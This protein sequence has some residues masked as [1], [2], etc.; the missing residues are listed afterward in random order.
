MNHTLV[1][2]TQDHIEPARDLFLESYSRESKH[3]PLLPS[4]I[5]DEPEWLL[6]E[7]EELIGN[8]GVAIIHKNQLI[9]YM[10]T[11]LQF[12]FKGQDAVVVSEYCHAAI[13]MNKSELYKRMYLHLAQEWANSH[14]HVHA[15]GHFANDTILQ[16]T[17]YQLGF[18]AILAEQLRD[19]SLIDDAPDATIIEEQDVERLVS[20]HIEH[21]AYYKASPIFILKSTNKDEVASE[22]ESHVQ[23][24]DVFLVYYEANEPCAYMIVGTSAIDEEG[25]LLQDTNTAQIK[26]A[27]ARP[28]IR[29]KGVGKALLQNVIEWSQQHGYERVFVEHETANFS[30]GNFWRNHFTPYMFFSM[31]YIDNRI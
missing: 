27:Y 15:I 25:F 16:E 11:E 8:P 17:L 13:M 1:P 7:L 10:L 9:A 29:G 14:R 3:S 20:L 4:R 22:L 12:S 30:G 19:L 24:G 5:F 2:F 21:N 31:R 26:V 28:H 23:D 18:G 6:E